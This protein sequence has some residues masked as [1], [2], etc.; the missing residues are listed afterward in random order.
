MVVEV[1]GLLAHSACQAREAGVPAVVLP[2][3]THLIENGAT[4]CLDGNRGTVEI[5]PTEQHRK[6]G[7]E[8]SYETV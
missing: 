3:A 2:E 1:G 8:R 7:H 4:I 6:S 5:L